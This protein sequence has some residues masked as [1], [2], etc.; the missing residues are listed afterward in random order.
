MASSI[1]RSDMA[2]EIGVSEAWRCGSSFWT[3]DREGGLRI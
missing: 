2:K 1:P 3:S